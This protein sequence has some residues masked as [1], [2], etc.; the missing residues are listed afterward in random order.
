VQLVGAALRGRPRVSSTLGRPQRAALQ[1]FVS[2]SDQGID[3]GGSAC[4]DVAG[5]QGH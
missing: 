3:F 5:D 1:L 2:E 4:G